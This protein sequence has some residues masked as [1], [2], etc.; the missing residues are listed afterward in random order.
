MFGFH[1]SPQQKTL[2]IETIN[3]SGTGHNLPF[4]NHQ[5]DAGVNVWYEGGIA[6]NTALSEVDGSYSLMVS[7]TGIQQPQ[8]HDFVAKPAKRQLYC[9]LEHS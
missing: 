4:Y 6:G 7:L 2:A 1:Y 8:I 9:R 3:I 5:P